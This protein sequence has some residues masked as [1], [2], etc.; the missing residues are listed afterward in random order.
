LLPSL[1]LITQAAGQTVH[2]GKPL[3]GQIDDRSAEKNCRKVSKRRSTI[4]ED[5]EVASDQEGDEEKKL[6]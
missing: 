5:V 2:R 4:V 6:F 1:V 3:E